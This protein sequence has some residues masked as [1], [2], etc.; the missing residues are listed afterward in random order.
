M[1]EVTLSLDLVLS[2]LSLKLLKDLT[3]VTHI[4]SGTVEQILHALRIGGHT[5]S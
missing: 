4:N 2:N 5:I 1:F 3:K